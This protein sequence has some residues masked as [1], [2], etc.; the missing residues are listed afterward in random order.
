MFLQ[1]I[2]SVTAQLWTIRFPIRLIPANMGNLYVVP[3]QLRKFGASL[4]LLRKLVAETG[5]VGRTNV[6]AG[7]CAG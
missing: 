3:K 1:E 6:E 4:L 5:S 2:L 7:W